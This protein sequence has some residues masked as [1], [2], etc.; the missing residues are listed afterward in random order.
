MNERTDL[1]QEQGEH[2]V[3]KALAAEPP[4]AVSIC[5]SLV[6]IAMAIAAVTMRARRTDTRFARIRR[7]A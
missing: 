3:A 4:L 1:A 2:V 6:G 5:L 7:H